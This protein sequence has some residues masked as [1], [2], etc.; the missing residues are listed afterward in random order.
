MH[1]KDTHASP[2]TSITENILAAAAVVDHNLFDLSPQQE[3]KSKLYTAA[4]LCGLHVPNKLG[5]ENNN[6]S[7]LHFSST[8]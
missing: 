5:V 3:F 8:T 2:L 6:A 1:R 4:I 7:Q